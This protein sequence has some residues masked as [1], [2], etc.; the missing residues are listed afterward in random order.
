MQIQASANGE[1]SHVNG[2]DSGDMRN[3][4]PRGLEK[5]NLEYYRMLILPADVNVKVSL[6]A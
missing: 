4:S 1:Q 3:I 5:G 6:I 2:K